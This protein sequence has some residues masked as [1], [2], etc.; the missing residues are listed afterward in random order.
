[1]KPGERVTLIKRLAQRLS[2]SDWP[3]IDL[4][5]RQFGIPWTDDWRGND[6]LQYCLAMLE[7]GTDDNL[8]QL[9]EYLFGES[10]PSNISA[11]GRWPADH[12]R[13]FISHVHSQ[14]GFITNLKGA[15][16]EYGIDGFVAHSDITPTA[17]WLEEIQLALETCHAMA[18]YLTDDFHQSLW[19]DQEVGYCLKRRV[20]IVPIKVDIDPYGFFAR[21]Q[22]LP[23]RGRTAAELAGDI[24]RTLTDNQL[25]VNE[26]TRAL[27]AKLAAARSYLEARNDTSLLERVKSW[28]PDL[29]RSLDE[30]LKNNDQVRD[31]WGIPERIQKIQKT[32]G[33]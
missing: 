24:Y 2:E 17:E 20:L 25:T 6:R 15:L 30:A 1:M 26:M 13:L 5:L 4:T 32:Y 7:N 19:T 3:E 14:K 29:L 12:F 10:H 28:T 9:N 16:S 22:A 18:A 33:Q 21:Y 27:L 11:Q 31:A 23:G 8:T